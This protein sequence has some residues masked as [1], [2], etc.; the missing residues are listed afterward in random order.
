[1]AAI[2]TSGSG[3]DHLELDDLPTLIHSPSEELAD[4]LLDSLGLLE[5]PSKE[6]IHKQL[7]EQFLTPSDRLPAHWLGTYQMSVA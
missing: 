5:L 3:V 2:S 7:E 1:M 6:K 4:D